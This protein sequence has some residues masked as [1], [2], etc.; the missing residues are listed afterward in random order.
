MKNH[1]SK[2]I[3][4]PLGAFIFGYNLTSF[5]LGFRIDRYGFSLDLAWLWMG[6]E[7]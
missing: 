5:G 2:V 4:T 6:W 3:H 1:K 7:R